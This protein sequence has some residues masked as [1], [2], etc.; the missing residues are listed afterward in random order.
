MDRLQGVG[1]DI[2][3]EGRGGV[4]NR[5]AQENAQGRVSG[6]RV[7]GTVVVEAEGEILL[8]DRIGGVEAVLVGLFPVEG[9]QDVQ[10][11]FAEPGVTDVERVPVGSAGRDR[12]WVGWRMPASSMP[13]RSMS[14]WV[15]SVIG[16]VW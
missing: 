6:G 5:D 2:L 8:V 7:L 13:L 14:I 9:G 4:V 11:C 15:G 12:T 1:L 3:V 16:C 10:V